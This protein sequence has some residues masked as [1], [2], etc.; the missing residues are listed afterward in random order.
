MSLARQLVKDSGWVLLARVGGVVVGLLFYSLITRTL[1]TDEVGSYF[2]AYAIALVLSTLAGLGLPK[3]CTRLIALAK[4]KQSAGSIS[5]ILSSSICLTIGG[6]ILTAIIFMTPTSRD[7]FSTLFS[8]LQT[9]QI[10][11]LIVVWM[12]LLSIRQLLAES[13]RGLGN[14]KLASIF[15]GLVGNS[16]GLSILA[17]AIAFKIS[18]IDLKDCVTYTTSG[19]L[20]SCLISILLLLKDRHGGDKSE[21]P[22][23]TSILAISTPIW[24]TETA[25]I[26]I[27]HSNTWI[28][29]ALSDTTQV[30]LF[31][32]AMQ[33]VILVSFPLIVINS[34]IPHLV[35]KLN[36]SSDKVRLS[37]LL[38]T[39]ATVSFIPAAAVVLLIAVFGAQVLEFVYGASYRAGA[40]VLLILAI[41]NLINVIAGPCGVVLIMTGHQKKN[42]IL[43][44]LTGAGSIPIALWLTPQYGA[45]GAAFAASLGIAVQN[46]LAS[47]YA[48]KT[49]GVR[50]HITSSGDTLKSL[51]EFK[52]T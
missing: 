52:L 23:Y 51:L 5:G 25:Q 8:S 2:L 42:M 49:L 34:A 45:I 44:V 36:A 6:A 21:T 46:T 7:I 22:T 32:T 50:T 26:A 20:I 47:I 29:G 33:L 12:F 9:Y 11:W 30:A 16:V 31:G 13:F 17:V 18:P 38:Q 27:T 37:N 10:T 35:V 24:I 19:L 41:G 40:P 28:V 4:T 15:G 39:V 43:T 48:Y 1:P 3:T 14:I